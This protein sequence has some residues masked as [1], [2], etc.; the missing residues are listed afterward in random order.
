[1]LSIIRVNCLHV[2]LVGGGAI[3]KGDPAAQISGKT[4]GSQAA[5]LYS[6]YVNKSKSLPSEARPLGG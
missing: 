6:L 5:S 1:V 3:N 4:L 2:Q